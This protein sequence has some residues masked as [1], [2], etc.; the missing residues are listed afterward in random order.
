M[1]ITWIIKSEKRLK[2]LQGDTSGDDEAL[3]KRRIVILVRNERGYRLYT[4]AL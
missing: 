4:F 3:K 1:V 2:E